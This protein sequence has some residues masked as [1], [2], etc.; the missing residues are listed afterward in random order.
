MAVTNLGNMAQQFQ[1]ARNT[2]AIKTELAAL[3]NSLSSGRVGDLTAVLGGD[4]RQYTGIT[5][6]LI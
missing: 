6:D 1:F 5:Y 4:S 2:T 3:G